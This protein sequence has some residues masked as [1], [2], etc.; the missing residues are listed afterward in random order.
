[1]HVIECALGNVRVSVLNEISVSSIPD[2][3]LKKLEHT[4]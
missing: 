2:S 1:M 3:F 4:Y